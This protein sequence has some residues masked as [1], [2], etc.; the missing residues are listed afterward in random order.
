MRGIFGVWALA[1]G[2]F[3][4]QNSSAMTIQEVIDTLG[5]IAALEQICPM[6]IYSK[7]EAVPSSFVSKHEVSLDLVAS[8]PYYNDWKRAERAAFERR[9]SN[10]IKHNCKEAL[11][12]YG[13]AGTVHEGFF[14]SS[15]DNL[16]H[17]N[18]VTIQNFLDIMGDT[19]AVERICPALVGENTA[20]QRFIEATGLLELNESVRIKIG[21]GFEKATDLALTARKSKSVKDNCDDGWRLYGPDGTKI[22][23]LF[24][25]RKSSN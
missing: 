21:E 3:F 6:L 23:G 13:P 7:D 22:P 10:S 5:D 2:M 4:T 9:F 24:T 25:A 1:C 18:N 11:R 16:S 14:S 20:G 8:G 12:L 17:Y 19:F 15:G